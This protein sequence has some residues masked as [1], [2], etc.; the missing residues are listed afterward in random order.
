MCA[1][2]RREEANQWKSVAVSLTSWEQAKEIVTN[3]AYA[4]FALCD[5]IPGTIK[6]ENTRS[7][8]RGASNPFKI[9]MTFVD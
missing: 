6:R 4:T 8:G 5:G 3:I 1:H 7:A 9:K 2:H